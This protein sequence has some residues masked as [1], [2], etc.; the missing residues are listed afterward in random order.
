MSWFAQHMAPCRSLSQCS[1]VSC[2]RNCGLCGRP[3]SC[4]NLE[5]RSCLIVRQCSEVWNVGRSGAQRHEG[6]TLTC[7]DGSRSDSIRDIGE[8]AHVDS[9]AK[10]KAHLS[11]AERAK[12]DETGR[13]MAAGNERADELAKKGAR[14]DSFQSTL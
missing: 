7:G 9:V 10:C 8:E 11:K 3:S 5:Q 2:G 12:L 4:R 6:R 14:D 13:F 1:A